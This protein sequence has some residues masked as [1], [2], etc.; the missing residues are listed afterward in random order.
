M[1]N[2]TQQRVFAVIRQV[3]AIISIAMGVITASVTQLHLP[4]AVSSVLVV[5]GGVI[6]AVEHYVADNSTGTLVSTTTTAV[7]PVHS[8]VQVQPQP[9]PAVPGNAGAP[10]TIPVIPAVPPP[11]A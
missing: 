8:V 5:A 7:Q 1:T 6:L 10:T 2:S 3:L 11:P 9:V 4:P